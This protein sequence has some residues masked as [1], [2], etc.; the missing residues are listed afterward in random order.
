[1]KR[2]LLFV[3]YKAKAHIGWIEGAVTIPY[4][5]PVLGHDDI[6][7]IMDKIHKMKPSISVDDLVICNWRRFESPETATQ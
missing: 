2:P 5:Q 7:N 4:D 6:K 1:M 3:N